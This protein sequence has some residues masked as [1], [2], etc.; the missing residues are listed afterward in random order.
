MPSVCFTDHA[1]TSET[2]M[3]KAFNILGRTE[4]AF[5]LFQNMEKHKNASELF[6]SGV[7]CS[8]LAIFSNAKHDGSELL[9]E[10]LSQVLRSYKQRASSI[11]QDLRLTTALI[12]A[13]SQVDDF[14]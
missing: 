8:L 12:K 14:L 5:Q 9:K 3:T 10:Q 13:Y 6:D 4:A 11:Q 7:Y 2:Q 1:S